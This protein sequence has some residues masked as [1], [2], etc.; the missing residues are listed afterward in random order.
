MMVIFKLTQNVI[1]SII[2]KR[3]LDH[4][5]SHQVMQKGGTVIHLHK[6]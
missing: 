4:C 5:M 3:S 1:V 6:D 2:L